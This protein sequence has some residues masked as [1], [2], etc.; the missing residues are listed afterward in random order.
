[1]RR[2]SM[3]RHGALKFAAAR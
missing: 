1:V 3:Q 2:V